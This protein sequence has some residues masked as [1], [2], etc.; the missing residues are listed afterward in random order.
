MADK[1]TIITLGMMV[2]Q[3]CHTD[4]FSI[5]CVLWLLLEQVLTYYSHTNCLCRCIA[6]L[7]YRLSPFGFKG[8][9]WSDE[10]VKVGVGCKSINLFAV[11]KEA[12]G[13]QQGVRG[14]TLL[15][16]RR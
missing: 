12:A 1:A 5:P 7:G 2:M 11:K 16:H 10:D 6:D 14:R 13:T 9:F 3:G 8:P 15:H 4:Q